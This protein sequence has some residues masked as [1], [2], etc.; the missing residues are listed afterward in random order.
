MRIA[1]PKRVQRFS[2][3]TLYRGRLSRRAD[4]ALP[5]ESRATTDTDFASRFIIV[6]LAL[7]ALGVAVYAGERP[8]AAWFLPSA[9]HFPHQLPPALRLLAG[10]LPSLLHVAALS[11]ATI[12][13]LGRSRIACVVACGSWT[14]INVLFEIGQHPHVAALLSATF[15]EQRGWLLDTLSAYFRRGTFDHAD[16]GAAVGG[17]GLAYA[18]SLVWEQES[19]HETD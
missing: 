15:H 1:D 13:L 4:C 12:A 11:L 19:R 8:T 9:L 10:W 14:S 3:A 16:L 7:L 17:G 18:L 2:L 5:R 6:A